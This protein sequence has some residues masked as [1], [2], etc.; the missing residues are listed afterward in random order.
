[1]PDVPFHKF[2]TTPH[3]LFASSRISRTDKLLN[4]ENRECLLSHIVTVEEKIDG[5]N[6]GISFDSSGDLLLQ[7]RGQYLLPPLGGQWKPLPNWI[8]AHQEKLFDVLE[9]RYILFGEWCY[10]RHSVFY[11]K[12]PDWFLGFDIYDTAAQRYLAVLPRDVLLKQAQIAS[13]P[14][15]KHGRFSLDEF[16]SLLG[17]S[18]FGEDLCEGLYFRYDVGNWLK[19]RAKFVRPSFTQAID[20]HW[21]NGQIQNNRIAYW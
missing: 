8:A 19:I 20:R 21:S 4:A 14:K 15:I 17:P 16:E 1:M 3:I 12:L 6:L 10:A 13:V 18:A 5:A 7:N 11:S 2:P 9:D